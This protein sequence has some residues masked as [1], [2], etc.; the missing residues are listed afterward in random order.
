MIR[1]ACILLLIAVAPL[2]AQERRSGYDDMTAEL[3]QMQDDE[4]SNPGMLWIGE[5]SEMWTQ[6]AGNAQKA[7]ADCHGDAAESMKGAAARY[8]AFDEALATPVDL[9][10]RVNLCRT[11]HQDAEP[12]E[13]EGRA[14]LAMTTFLTYQSK[15]MPIAPS[16]DPRLE[17]WL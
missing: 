8:P 1:T 11:R 14:L 7:C 15:G 13:R 16:E 9:A 10:G 3:Q 4:F 12:L 17:P 2:S 6:P 5:G